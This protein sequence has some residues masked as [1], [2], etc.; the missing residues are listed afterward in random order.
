MALKK[1][2]FPALKVPDDMAYI[3]G[4]FVITRIALTAV[5]Y[6]AH[7]FLWKQSFSG[8]EAFTKI[9]TVW[10]GRWYIGIARDGYSALPVNSVDMA[11]YAF[12]PLYPALMRLASFAVGDYALAGII[13]SNVCLLVACYYIYRY[14]GLD[15]DR[16]TAKRSVKYLILFPA[17]F[18]FSAVLT[19][20]LFVALVIACLYYARKGNWL[21]AGV[22]GFF[23]PLARLPG[24]AIVVPLSYEY[25]RQN[26][27]SLRRS[28]IMQCNVGEAGGA[29][30][31]D[32]RARPGAFLDGNYYLTGD[33][34]G[35]LRI[36]STWGGHMVLP[37]VELLTRLD[38]D[39]GAIF[40][41]AVFTVAALALMLLFYRKVD[42]G[43]WTL[44]IILILI[45]M[46]SAQSCYSM[47]RYLAVVFPLFII[48]AKVTKDKRV[49]TA[50]TVVLIVVEGIF[51]ALWTTWSSLIV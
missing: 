22:L 30:A 11:N 9:W 51:M 17:A 20:S 36:Q 1:I 3:L 38:P 40:T 6:F 31:A 8:L 28:R 44:G 33:F 15:S 14:V 18:V 27:P 41:G 19:E 13:V 21:V 47:L 45:P 46:F 39:N 35:F 43:A 29:R 10:D 16:A 34:L 2:S 7:D 48:A 4:L 12:F 26:A 24:L 50:L 49:D 5:G 32:A 23:V 42:F 37:P 25:V